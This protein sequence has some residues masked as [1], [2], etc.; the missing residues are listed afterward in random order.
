MR[1]EKK[2]LIGSW[3]FPLVQGKARVKEFTVTQTADGLL[4]KQPLSGSYAELLQNPSAKA[5]L[6]F[7]VRLNLSNVFGRSKVVTI[8]TDW[9]RIGDRIFKADKA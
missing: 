4:L 7:A 2:L 5:K 9:V 3:S 1:R 6:P 8:G